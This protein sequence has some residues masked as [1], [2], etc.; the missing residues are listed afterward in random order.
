MEPMNSLAKISNPAVQNTGMEEGFSATL[1][2][3]PVS[4]AKRSTQ[5]MRSS[6][7]SKLLDVNLSMHI[8]EEKEEV[9]VGFDDTLVTSTQELDKKVKI[10]PVTKENLM[11]GTGDQKNL[12]TETDTE[13]SH[14]FLAKGGDIC[15]K[16]EDGNIV[17]E[18]P[19]EETMEA[20]DLSLPKKRDRSFRSRCVWITGDDAANESS[21]VMEV[22]EI[23]DIRTEPEVEEDDYS[24]C[25]LGEMQWGN[26][27]AT[28]L[29]SL[30]APLDEANAEDMLLIDIEG[31][32]YTL[33]P[34]GTKVP[35]M[36]PEE[37][38][39]QPDSTL[40]ADQDQPCSSSTLTEAVLS[41]QNLSHGSVLSNNLSCTTLA[42]S[43]SFQNIAV[44]SSPVISNLSQ[45]SM[46]PALSS[47]SSQPIQVIANSTS[48]TPILLLPSSQL[49]TAS[50]SGS[51]EAN[52][53][54]MALSLPLTL[55]QNTQSSPM[56]LVL[57]SLPV[58]STQTSV[59]QLPLL[60][61]SSGQLS[62][63][64]SVSSVALPLTA[65]LPSV[66]S[67]VMASNP[68]VVDLLVPESQCST[69]SG[70]NTL[71]S[72]SPVPGTVLPAG[73]S[74]VSSTSHSRHLDSD[75][76]DSWTPKSFREALLR[77]TYSPENRT[78]HP[79]D[80]QT[81]SSE[82]PATSCPS[83]SNPGPTSPL[84]TSDLSEEPQSP[85]GKLLPKPE[86]EP[87]PI[88]ENA[89]DSV[90]SQDEQLVS[91]SSPTPPIS[92]SIVGMY[93]ANQPVVSPPSPSS[94]A[95]RVLYCRYCPRIFYYL[96]DL[97]RH[98]ITHSQSKPHV[99]PLCGK[100]F[101]RSSHLERH[102]HIH[103]GQRNFVC[104]ICSKR[105][106]EAGELL[107]H[108]RV[109]TGEK[110]FQ[111]SLCHMRFAERNTLRRHTKRKHQGREHEAM[112]VDGGR[113][114]TASQALV[115]VQQEES[116]EWY[117]STVPEQDSD[118]EL[119]GDGDGDVE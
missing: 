35:Q 70:S 93:P 10:E 31:V 71:A 69:A 27:Q 87:V 3:P 77:P 64:S 14:L 118:S 24:S 40:T 102:K 11:A 63:I 38:A 84:V 20:L 2:K 92:P 65:S 59:T 61:A 55:A 60:N 106:R 75:K 79:P 22:D 47:L 86:P 39:D 50:S 15:F 42:T 29:A 4:G 99:C 110:P 45:L 104:S 19:F 48:N 36:D 51:G 90:S 103:T 1:V 116:A 9:M 109:H 66:R 23:E 7:D 21:L 30:S 8:K 72:P 80:T 107:R 49:Q 41:E 101:K 83:P 74:N 91:S 25:E 67:G 113:V 43:A 6:S 52:A 105:F 82:V 26:F 53:G 73:A 97:E 108:Q 13:V 78:E 34:D 12:A 44:K 96:S 112:E 119:D 68:P 88:S 81:K 37:Q 17:K 62:Q 46:L 33:T 5:G 18:N 58:S 85:K 54:L 95:R 117:S 32:P 57:S 28:D 115:L 76:S 111:C 56:F 89:S 114:G 94:C 16:V 98:S 100:A